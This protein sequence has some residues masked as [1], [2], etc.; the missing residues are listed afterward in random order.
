MVIVI[1]KVQISR[2]IIV[3]VTIAISRETILRAVIVIP[4]STGD[5]LAHGWV[6]EFSLFSF[7]FQVENK[8]KARSAPG[9]QYLNCQLNSTVIV[10]GAVIVIGIGFGGITWSV[11]TGEPMAEIKA[12]EGRQAGVVKRG[13]DG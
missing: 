3:T 9:L 6:S 7:G 13:L 11:A 5:S 1:I 4:R 2:S 10:T 8:Y 12:E